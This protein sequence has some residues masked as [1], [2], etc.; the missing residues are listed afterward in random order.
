[1]N[2]FQFEFDTKTER[3]NKMRPCLGQDCTNKV[4]STGETRLCRFCHKENN[5]AMYGSKYNSH[6]M[7]KE[8]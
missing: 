1:M 5:I 7:D 8:E 4:K 3:E 2:K 6:G